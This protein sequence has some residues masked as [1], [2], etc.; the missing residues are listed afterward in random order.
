MKPAL[1]SYVRA[2]SASEAV[3]LL[4][5]RPG[6][7][8]LLA[9]GQSLMPLLNMRLARPSVVV[10][11]NR[12]PDMDRVVVTSEQIEVGALTR[13]SSIERSEAI[14]RWLP[15]L[16]EGVRLIGDRQ[17]RNRGTVGGAL[18]HGDPTGEVP[19]VAMALGARVDVLGPTGTREVPVEELYLGP[20]T[21]VLR[22]D[23]MI[24]RVRLPVVPGRIGAIEE[25][26][27]RH[28]DFAIVAVAAT[29]VPEGGG[30]WG[31]VRLTLAGVG[32]RA[33]VSSE[34]GAALSGTSLDEDAVERGVR[35]CLAEADPSDDAR[36]SAEYRLHLLPILVQRVLEQLVSRREALGG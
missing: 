11:I 16:A 35:V 15:L 7:V 28:G 23:E 2:R 6:E 14:R 36:A 21:T 29:G 4:A 18:A 27:R 20:Y 8:R 24:M 34:A 30:R 22:P 26:T 12:I 10:D 33:F 19:L 31:E 1:F 32:P 5:E 17:I 25:L 13:Y 9:G 3:R